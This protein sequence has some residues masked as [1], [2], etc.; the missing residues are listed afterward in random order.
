M[1]SIITPFS[2]PTANAAFTGL[3]PPFA[4][5]LNLCYFA[6]VNNKLQ[7]VLPLGWKEAASE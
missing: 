5:S 6:M 1:I 7:L 2:H 3:D 4:Q